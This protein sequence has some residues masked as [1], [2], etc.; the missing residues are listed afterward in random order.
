MEFEEARDAYDFFTRII[1]SSDPDAIIDL[2]DLDE[3]SGY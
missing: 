3:Y 2:E 1:D